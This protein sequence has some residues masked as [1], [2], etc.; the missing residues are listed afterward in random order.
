MISEFLEATK[1]N[2]IE[3][4]LATIGILAVI[5]MFIP[6]ES[7]L[8]KSLGVF[9]QFFGILGKIFSRKG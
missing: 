8:G 7:W 2:L 6:K 3:L 4:A 5:T 9:E 1:M